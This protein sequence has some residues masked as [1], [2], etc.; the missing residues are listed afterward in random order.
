MAR[1]DTA[2]AEADPRVA[3]LAPAP[4]GAQAS[5]DDGTAVDAAEL[6][7]GR[8]DVG[9]GSEG[10]AV[11]EL[12][13]LLN[14]H[15]ASARPLK[16]T[17][18]FDPATEAAL[19]AFQFA[20]PGLKPTGIA[21]AA[22]WAALLRRV[23]E[24][25]GTAETPA[26]KPTTPGAKPPSP[27]PPK[28]KVVKLQWKRTTCWCSEDNGLTGST[29]NYADGENLAITVVDA[30]DGS[31]V[32]TFSASVASNAVDVPW[33]PVTDVLP[34]GKPNWKELRELNGVAGGVETAKALTVKF[35]PTLAKAQ[36]AHTAEY[37][38]TDPGAAASHKVGVPCEFALEAKDYKL[39]IHGTMKYVRGR[40]RERLIFGGAALPGGFPL[41]GE[42]N[43]WG[44]MDPVSGGF[45]YWNGADWVDAPS[46]PRWAPSQS[47]HFGVAFYKSG[48]NWV[49]RDAPGRAW[50]APLADWADADYKGAG[51]PT[52]ATLRKWVTNINKVWGSAFDI[53][54]VECKSAL[55]ECCRYKT[56]CKSEFKEVAAYGEHVII[57]VRELIRSDSGLWALGDTREGLAPHEF[58]HLLGAPDEY[59]GVGTT[60][61]G[62]SDHDGLADGIDDNC[63][64]GVHLTAAKKR[65]FKGIC[66][67]LALIVADQKGKR[68]TYKAVA[69]SAT[70]AGS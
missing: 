21:D 69:K 9:R 12:Q 66:E 51:N 16:S 23:S 43:H 36:K 25:G 33:K 39:T 53:K 49:S 59:P 48:A 5:I 26:P 11:A 38:R 54:R 46:P 4:L 60:Q 15:R 64:M 56:T 63:I 57:L 61:L 34:I 40:G 7:G 22:T 2:E 55:D 50:P 62:V 28:K 65:H 35:I 19:R 31:T 30:E 68:Y 32:K 70:L 13:K 47:N 42:V 37:D 52:D 14:A 45:K 8:P 17:S 41:F 58:G 67:M 20:T 6:A 29:V 18:V 27:E 3:R 44:Y 1:A 24:S 10:P